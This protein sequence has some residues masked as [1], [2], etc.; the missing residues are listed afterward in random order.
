MAALY[1]FSLRF[2]ADTIFRAGIPYLVEERQNGHGLVRLGAGLATLPPVPGGCKV[3]RFEDL[4]HL[5]GPNPYP[6]SIFGA[7]IVGL[8][9]GQMRCFPSSARESAH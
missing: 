1:I 3:L 7:H 9:S 2:L 4:S 6:N 5:T 8:A